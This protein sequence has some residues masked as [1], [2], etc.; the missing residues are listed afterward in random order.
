[1]VYRKGE[2]EGGREGGSKQKGR[3][4]IWDR[5]RNDELSMT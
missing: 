1:V 2:R 4:S 3:K 5:T